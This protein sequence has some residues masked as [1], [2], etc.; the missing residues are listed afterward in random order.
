MELEPSANGRVLVGAVV[1]A[2]QMDLSASVLAVDGREEVDELAV[3]VPWEA[4]TVNL[5][6]GNLKRGEEA[7]RAVA[8]VVVGHPRRQTRAHRQDRLRPVESLDLRLLVHAQHQRTLRR[9]EVEPDDVRHLGFELGVR[10]E[11]ERR[12][13]VRLQV[14][15][16]PDAMD[17]GV[18]DSRLLR[19]PSRAPV[20]RIPRRGK[21]LRH[22]RAFLG[23]TDLARPARTSPRLDSRQ[24]LAFVARSP[25]ANGHGRGP[26][27]PRHLPHALA[28]C[29]RQNDP[30]AKRE[31]LGR[32]RTSQP[33]LKNRLIATPELETGGCKG[34]GRVCH[35]NP[36]C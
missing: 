22:H 16:L 15:C 27:P 20:R 7:R 2:D 1:V 31:L 17:G 24:A 5:A 30:S 12:R 13:P 18:A 8:P 10:A 11:L 14:V 9:I 29:T 19:Q 3:R 32:R 25:L 6:T 34:H 36:S 35:S 26:E 33:S 23:R 28:C 21:R 4:E